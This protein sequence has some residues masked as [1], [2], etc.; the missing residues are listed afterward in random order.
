MLFVAGHAP[1][2]TV[3]VDKHFGETQL[4]KPNLRALNFLSMTLKTQGKIRPLRLELEKKNSQ[5]LSK[6]YFVLLI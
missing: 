4:K 5:Q 2:N 3:G 6:L 1:Q